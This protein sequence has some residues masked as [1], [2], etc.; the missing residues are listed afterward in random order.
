LGSL[1]AYW[2]PRSPGWLRDGAIVFGC[3]NQESVDWLINL[4]GVIR[5]EDIPLRVLPANKPPKHHRVVLHVE[6]TDLIAEET[7][8]FLDRSGCWGM[9]REGKRKQGR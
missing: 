9:D 8:K 1:R 2:P 5:V 4:F 3:T 6:E 7:V